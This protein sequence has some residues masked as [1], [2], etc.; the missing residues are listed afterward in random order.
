M[1]IA[2]LGGDARQIFL[3]DRLTRAG[4]DVLLWGVAGAPE[5]A[6]VP[7]E[8]A[9]DADLILLPQPSSRDG[10]T[11]FAPAAE[12]ELPLDELAK[13]LPPRRLVLTAGV[14]L[15]GCRCID[16][17]AREELAVLGAVPT[18]EAAIEIA[19]HETKRTLWEAAALV[20]GYGRIGRILCDRLAGF[21]CR[22]TAT[23]RKPA[24]FAAIRAAGFEYRA[25]ADLAADVDRYDLVFNTVPHTVLDRAAL[26]RLRPGALVIDLASMPGGVDAPAAKALGVRVIHALA[27]PGRYAP[28]TAADAIFATVCAILAEQAPGSTPPHNAEN[29]GCL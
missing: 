3:Y 24:D 11:L 27:L 13:K 4:H 12:R 21:G 20:I 19:M 8:T 18:A 2:I 5:A 17:G 28:E 16:Y 15:P 1:K 10:K 25:T 14:R 29:G 6:A 22:V 9:L 26:E 23:A 7:L